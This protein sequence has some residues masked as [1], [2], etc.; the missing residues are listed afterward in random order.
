MSRLVRK[1]WSAVAVGAIEAARL[2]PGIGR[3]RG[4]VPASTRDTEEGH[5][6]EELTALKRDA[7]ALAVVVWALNALA[8][9]GWIGVFF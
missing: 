2:F 5:G 9:V 7:R 3:V 6:W 4:R 8:A 1:A